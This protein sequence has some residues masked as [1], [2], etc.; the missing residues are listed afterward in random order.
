MKATTAC[1]EGGGGVDASPAA[2]AHPHPLHGADAI[3]Q[4]TNC[5]IDLW[6]ELLHGWGLDPRA[7]LPFTVAQDFEGDHF[8]FFKYPQMDLETLYGTVVQEMAVYDTLQA[9]VL[10]QVER[11]HTVLLEVDSYYL[12]DTHATAYRREHVKT[13]VAIDRIDSQAQ[14]LWYY[15]SLGYHSAQHEDYRGLLRLLPDLSGNGNILFPYAECAKRVRPSLESSALIDA[16]VALMRYHLAR[17]PA[18]N[19]VGRWRQVFGKHMDALLARDEAYFHLYTFNFPRQLGANFE[20]LHH[21]LCWLCEQ[22]R[23]APLAAV[24]AARTIA[25]ESKVLQFRLARAVARRRADPCTDCL[26]TLEACHDRTMEG[27]ITAFGGADNDPIGQIQP[28]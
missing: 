20:M 7:G 21:W 14:R 3:W 23:E 15:H 17:R 25:T 12:P 5:Y 11:G 18:A 6:V 10:A 27:L 13:T 4:E 2:I 24:D 22:G 28:S 16:S 8:T 19:P 9:H 1:G 26:D